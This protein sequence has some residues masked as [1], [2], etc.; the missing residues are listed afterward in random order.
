MLAALGMGLSLTH[1]ESSKLAYDTT[2]WGDSTIGG[3]SKTR[4]YFTT[5]W[6]DSKIRGYF[7]TIWGD[8][9]TRGY[10]T[11]IWGDSKTRGYT[12]IWGD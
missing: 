3:D 10:F 6:G 2:N 4:G 8:S 5:I 7:T 1:A 12:T 11:T 9:K